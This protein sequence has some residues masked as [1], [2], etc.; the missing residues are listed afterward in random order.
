MAIVTKSG[1]PP[2][3]SDHLLDALIEY[4]VYRLDAEGRVASWNKGA[5][6]AIGFTA[7]EILG[8]RAECFFTPEDRKAGAFRNLL[9]E[10]AAHGSVRTQG[11]R[12]RKDG[13]PFWS[14]GALHAVRDEAGALTGYAEI[15]RDMTAERT[16]RDD[17]MQSE[18]RFRLLVE[19]VVDYA[20]FMLDVNGTVTNWNAGAERI[21]GYRADEVVGSHFSR[22]YTPEDRRAGLPARALATA[23]R[24]GR[25]EA[26]GWRMRKD[27]SRFWALVVID[28]VHDDD[29]QLIGFA[30]ITRDISER[31]AAEDALADSERQF[32][33]LVAGVVDYALYML[34][35]N[36][37]VANW[38]AGA[39]KIKGYRA[40]DIV[41]QHFSRFYTEGDRAAGVPARALQA[42]TE[43]GR[44]EAEGWRVR[45]DGSLF[46]A[47]VV[48][49]AI[50]DEDG[51]LL[52]FAKI[53]RDIT[54]K[55]TAQLELQRAHEQLAQ[56]QKMEALG[57]LTGGVA[58]DFNNLLMVV[59]GQAQLLRKRVADDARALRALD[60]I[61]AS[62]KR[63]EDLT[64]HLLA[65]SRRQRLQPM[66]ISLA[67][68]LED[69]R[70]LIATSLPA[71]ISLDLALPDDL[72]PVK[73]DPSELELAL[74]NLAV[75]ARDAMSTGG[76]LS[77]RAANATLDRRDD[78]LR[79][80]FVA[81]TVEDNGTGIPA[82]IL[83]R[84]FDPFFTTKEV[85]KGTGL[86]LSQVYGFAEQSGGRVEV[87]SQLGRG[88]RFTLYLPRSG[89]SAE[90][91]PQD[92]PE[93][94][95]ASARILLVED[96]PEV[97]E[98]AAAMLEQLGHEVRLASSAAKALAMLGEAEPPD[99][100]FSDIVMAGEIDGLGLARQIREARPQLPVLLA[101]GYSQA[102]EG[103]SG[104]FPILRKPY[105]LAELS[106][107]IGALLGPPEG[108]GGR[109]GGDPAQK[110]A[111][112]KLVDLD[113]ARS[114][115]A[116]RDA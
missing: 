38:N 60:A 9:R 108:G 3:T 69:L 40:E 41:G 72:W 51:A 67:E 16:A 11:W 104:E 55:R 18:R 7:S 15:T 63:G 111:D 81:V 59:A 43:Q 52:G 116:R 73:V 90:S 13:A 17:L 113:A 14:E 10:A 27:G 89:G 105:R 94:V 74:L 106:R 98:V 80:E 92:E 99:L 65:F 79:G 64:R 46:W 96:N 8:Q 1:I 26:E 50:R 5:E 114:R 35:P 103:L 53:T 57:K 37:V 82:D 34:D 44:Y 24:E 42:A 31:K 21:K 54:E 78:A 20:I 56:A 95:A 48:I 86:G 91:L 49:D 87:D 29:G 71:S 76:A 2:Q 112:G 88:T 36:G 109:R 70:A 47:S 85:S 101:T 45:K 4:A 102:A 19:S 107:A 75:N 93:H 12:V 32:R 84:I 68:R 22:F 58:H 28:A 110:D 115:R 66:S 33:L 39:A 62:A 100:V 23:S 6:R 97:A 83:P 61:E 25:F 30:K 77:I